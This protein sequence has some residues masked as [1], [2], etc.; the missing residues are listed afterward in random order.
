MHLYKISLDSYLF[1][2][3]DLLGDENIPKVTIGASR[4]PWPVRH[5]LL[6]RIQPLMTNRES[7]FQKCQPISSALAQKLLLC[8]YKRH[9][10]FGFWD[11]IKV[12][13]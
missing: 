12:S 1:Y 7:L 6:Q 13:H 10:A 4:K 8:S 3:Q 9:S 11:P 5:Q 2:Q